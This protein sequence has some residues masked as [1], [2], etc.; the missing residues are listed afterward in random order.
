MICSAN[1]LPR[2]TTRPEACRLVSATASVIVSDDESEIT[3]G[4]E[5]ALAQGTFASLQA[6][7]TTNETSKSSCFRVLSQ[8]PVDSSSASSLLSA[9]RRIVERRVEWRVSILPANLP[10]TITLSATC[11]REYCPSSPSSNI[12]QQ[13]SQ[14]FFPRCHGT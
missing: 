5:I 10:G 1:A 11:F 2:D 14:V 7:F 9:P 6:L 13:A 4:E 12:L 8:D 3:E